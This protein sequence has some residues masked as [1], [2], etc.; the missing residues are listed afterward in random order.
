MRHIRPMD[1][2]HPR[3]VLTPYVVHLAVKKRTRA[4]EFTGERSDPRWGR[5]LTKD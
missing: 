1:H 5:L 3:V 2:A 4:N